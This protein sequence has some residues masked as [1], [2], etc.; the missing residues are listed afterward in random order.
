[1]HRDSRSY[2]LHREE[3]V[4]GGRNYQWF[5]PNG[6]KKK[7]TFEEWRKK[8]TRVVSKKTL[9]TTKDTYLK[10]RKKNRQGD[11]PIPE[12]KKRNARRLEA[13]N[14]PK[15]EGEKAKKETL[16]AD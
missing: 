3:W 2:N 8:L 11:L 5:R 12:K 14:T 16:G 13:Q 1:M 15:S 9:Q 10:K 7:K 4:T 6:T